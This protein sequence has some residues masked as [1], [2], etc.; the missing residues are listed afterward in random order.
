MA[1]NPVENYAYEG[2]ALYGGVEIRDEAAQA[3]RT[4][5]DAARLAAKLAAF[6][7]NDATTSGLTWGHLRTHV[8]LYVTGTNDGRSPIDNGSQFIEA[9][10]VTLT[11]STTNYAEF[12]PATDI[13]ECNAVGFTA[14]RLPLYEIETGPTGIETLTDRRAWLQTNGAVTEVG[15]GGEAAGPPNLVAGMQVLL[16]RDG[17]YYSTLT[18]GA[19]DVPL[20]IGGPGNEAIFNLA[21][22][23]VI[24]KFRFY[25]PSGG[26]FVR[27]MARA[28]LGD[29]TGPTVLASVGSSTAGWNEITVESQTTWQELMVN[30]QTSSTSLSEVEIIG[31]V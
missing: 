24:T 15:N 2:E 27:L 20:L 8:N 12:N 11:A 18:D 29:G 10:T 4:A 14:G 13:V 21:A 25:E 17:Q 3:V 28:V 19:T 30:I 23:E 5:Q 7:Q 26:K 22:P 16:A 9:G 31:A 6:G 1:L